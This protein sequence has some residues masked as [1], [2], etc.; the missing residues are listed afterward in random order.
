VDVLDQDMKLE[1]CDQD[2]GKQHY[3]GKHI[4][5]HHNRRRPPCRWCGQMLVMRTDYDEQAYEQ[6]YHK[7]CLERVESMESFAGVKLMVVKS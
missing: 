5:Y 6:G 1:N 7:S 4:V 3:G 2:C